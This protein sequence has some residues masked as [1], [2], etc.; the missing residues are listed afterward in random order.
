[1]GFV[2][3]IYHMSLAEETLEGGLEPR[4]VLNLSK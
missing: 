1:M 2:E 3:A 4:S